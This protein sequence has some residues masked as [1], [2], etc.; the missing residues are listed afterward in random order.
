M[1]S[2]RVT[3]GKETPQNPMKLKLKA[4]NLTNQDKP[5]LLQ[6]NLL[7]VPIPPDPSTCKWWE[8]GLR[9]MAKSSLMDNWTLTLKYLVAFVRLFFSVCFQMSAQIASN[10]QSADKGVFDGQLDLD[11][12]IYGN[13]KCEFQQI[14][15]FNT[16]M[17]LCNCTPLPFKR[18]NKS[19]I[20]K[21]CTS[22]GGLVINTVGKVR[23]KFFHERN[24]LDTSNSIYSN[25]CVNRK[26]RK[27]NISPS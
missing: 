9:L 5:D 24:M 21:R 16:R 4:I 19:N 14:V 20:L 17:I 10:C 2:C 3:E 1:T 7:P 15:G 18:G 22:R 12:W 26:K 6:E 27:L 13:C 11:T 25:F 23:G 8:S